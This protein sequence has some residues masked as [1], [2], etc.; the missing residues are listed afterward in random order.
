MYVTDAD[1]YMDW[2]EQIKD[3]KNQN[4]SPTSP[5]ADIKLESGSFKVPAE[6]S[7]FSAVAGKVLYISDNDGAALR[8][9]ADIEK[10]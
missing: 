5:D 7:P 3:K 4:V 9:I 8:P 1:K 2:L 6:G 10:I